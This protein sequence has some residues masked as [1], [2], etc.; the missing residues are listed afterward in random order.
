M[1]NKLTD[2]TDV[3]FRQ[4][5]D[6]IGDSRLAMLTTQSRTGRMYSRPM[7]IQQVDTQGALWFFTTSSG[8]LVQEITEDPWIN[9]AIV[10]EEKQQFLSASAQASLVMDPAKMRSLWH[11]SLE[12][13]FPEGLETPE[14]CLLKVLPDEVEYWES[15]SAPVV[16]IAG[17]IKSLG[18]DTTSAGRHEKIDLHS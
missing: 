8:K 4:V 16:S 13:W 1:E 11:P 9:L 2:S 3:R 10:R 15:P 17:F 5:A 18:R 14:L 12:S 7:C 6:M